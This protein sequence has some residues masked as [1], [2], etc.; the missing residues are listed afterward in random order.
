MI[1]SEGLLPQDIGGADCGATVPETD[2][3][4]GALSDF[5]I[6]DSILL[7]G[8]SAFDVL[9][10]G[11]DC[12]TP[13]DGETFPHQLGNLAAQTLALSYSIGAFTTS[14]G[15]QTL[16]DVESC[17][18]DEGINLSILGLTLGTTFVQVLTRA[19][20]LIDDST[21][22][23]SGSTTQAQVTTMTKLLGHCVN[24]IGASHF[25]SAYPSGRG[26][27]FVAGYSS[28]GGGGFP[29][30]ALLAGLGSV[31]AVAIAAFIAPWVKASRWRRPNWWLYWR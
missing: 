6:S 20:D 13:L 31:I 25:V 4:G 1:I 12:E 19:N 22:T 26:D 15:S 27:S 8:I 28:G 2:D 17:I 5:P 24:R 16:A 23:G 18:T 3:D 9:A 30:L 10:A 14:F 7:G 29:L 11:G 21:S